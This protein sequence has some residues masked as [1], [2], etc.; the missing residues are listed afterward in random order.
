VNLADVEIT[1][2][3]SVVVVRLLGEI[4]L[5]N[6]RGIEEAIAAGTPNHATTVVLNLGELEFIDSAGIQLLYQLRE[7]LQNRGQDLRL[8]IPS[9]SVAADA[10]RLAGVLE[11]LSASETL[12]A[13]LG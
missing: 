2:E 13:A 6:A 8:V 11:Y 12:R 1:V 3:D 7:R 9:D 5:S 10:L 4:D